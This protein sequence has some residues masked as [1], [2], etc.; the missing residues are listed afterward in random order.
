MFQRMGDL[1]KDIA[2]S[3]SGMSEE[4]AEI[5]SFDKNSQPGLGEKFDLSA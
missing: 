3:R 5:R 1:L 2:A 4:L